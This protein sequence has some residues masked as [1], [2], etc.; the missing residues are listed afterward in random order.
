MVKDLALLVVLKKGEIYPAAFQR[1]NIIF[2][3]KNKKEPGCS[4]IRNREAGRLVK[5][6]EFGIADQVF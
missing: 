4:I 5:R 3:D 1:V 6:L 2:A